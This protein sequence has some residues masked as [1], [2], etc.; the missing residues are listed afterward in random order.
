MSNF[1]D[2]SCLLFH[3]SFLNYRWHSIED[4]LSLPWLRFLSKVRKKLCRCNKEIQINNFVGQIYVMGIREVYWDPLNMCGVFIRPVTKWLAVANWNK[5]LRSFRE[6][7]VVH[8]FCPCSSTLVPIIAPSNSLNHPRGKGPLKN[9]SDVI[10][11]AKKI[12][13]AGSRMDKL[14]RAVA[15]QV[16]LKL[17]IVTLTI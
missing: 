9:S 8:L 16:A 3:F 17:L 6:R 11:A 7:D 15:D 14:A 1:A 13:E 4:F 5:E 10:N 2:F 12:A